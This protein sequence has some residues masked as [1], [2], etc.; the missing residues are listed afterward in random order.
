[1]NQHLQISE[2]QLEYLN[3]FDW[4]KNMRQSTFR[5]GLIFL[6]TTFYGNRS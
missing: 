2:F 4:A 5:K 6:K 1:M 3:G